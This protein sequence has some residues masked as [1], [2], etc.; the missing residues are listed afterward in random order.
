MLE[1][2]FSLSWEQH[3]HNISFGL[4]KFQQSGE[5]VDLT[6]AADGYFVKAHQMILSLVSPYIKDIIT[7]LKCSHPVIFL[8]NISYKTL[9]SILDYVYKGEVQVSKEQLEDLIQAGKV[10]QIKGLQEMNPHT[11]ALNS[12]TN[13][14]MATT[15]TSTDTKTENVQTKQEV[16]E[17]SQEQLFIIDNAQ[18]NSEYI[19]QD[20]VME[21]GQNAQ[22]ELNEQ[23]NSELQTGN[24]SCI[25]KNSTLNQDTSEFPVPFFTISNQGSLQLVLNGFIYFLKYNS[26]SASGH[27]QWKCVNYV[28][29]KCQAYVITK[30]DRVI[31]RH[32]NH[33]H[34][35]H[36]IKIAKKVSTG[37]I[38]CTTKSAE[39]FA[40]TKKEMNSKHNRTK[41]SLAST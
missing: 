26:T 37:E 1:T 27:S 31:Q 29:T 25:I 18:S 10:L 23:T 28:N 4:S 30:N 5:F 34:P 33:A 20:F 17:D 35:T 39:E 6:L 38:F 24:F 32:S 2:Q 3:M 22:V 16:K 13:Q 41:K 21:E 40:R 15:A 19:N 8:T 36:E 9:C 14:I 7:S 12:S 11:V